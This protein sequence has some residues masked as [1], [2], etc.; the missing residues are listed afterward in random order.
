MQILLR[1]IVEFLSI[2][3]ISINANL[4]LAFVWFAVLVSVTPGPNC[5]VALLTSAKFGLVSTLPHMLGVMAGFS[6]LLL[7]CSVGAYALLISVPYAA[8]TLKWAGIAYLVWMGWTLARSSATN[9]SKA[10]PPEN[11][12]TFVKP[13]FIGSALFQFANPKAWLLATGAIAAYQSMIKPF[14]LCVAIMMII[15]AASCALGIFVWAYVGSRM[16]HWLQVGSRAILFNRVAGFSLILT[17][18]TLI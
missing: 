8:Q 1:S 16:Q 13:H 14:A 6:A 7:A 3:S 5:T 15:C 9:N 18:L 17:A 12:Q 11:S 4:L 2:Q 10:A